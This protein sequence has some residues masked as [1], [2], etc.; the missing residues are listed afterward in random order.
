MLGG[1]ENAVE[2]M[3]SAL[4]TD[5][6]KDR[7]PCSDPGMLF[8]CV[9][10][11]LPTHLHS[12]MYKTFYIGWQSIFAVIADFLNGTS[13]PLS[14]DA[15]VARSAPERSADFFFRKGGRV[16]YAFDALTDVALQ[17]SPSG[18]R[19]FEDTWRDQDVWIEMP[20]C[21]NDLEFDL[22]RQMLGLSPN[23]RWGP[24]RGLT[25]IESS[26]GEDSGSDSED[27]EM[28]VDRADT[29]DDDSQSRRTDESLHLNI[30]TAEQE[31]FLRLIDGYMA[32]RPIP[33]NLGL[34]H[35]D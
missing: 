8:D 10:D 6:F 27:S 1:A 21:E 33:T 23:V 18:D 35:L 7:V 25:S 19:D 2:M 9:S 24:Y 3:Y 34:D 28:S 5:L 12:S 32:S 17:Q 11:Y 30:P 20:V 13:Q 26:E 29:D 31:E 15:I 16:E 4:A 22:V 14:A